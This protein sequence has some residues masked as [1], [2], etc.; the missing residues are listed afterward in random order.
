MTPQPMAGVF[1]LSVALCGYGSPERGKPATIRPRDPQGAGPSLETLS[2][3]RHLVRKVFAEQD[4]GPVE[5]R[6]QCGHRDL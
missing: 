6:L 5:A 3:G 1:L 2:N 4:T